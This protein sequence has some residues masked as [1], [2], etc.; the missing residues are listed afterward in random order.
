MHLNLPNSARVTAIT[1]A[2]YTDAI[3]ALFVHTY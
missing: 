3:Y 1:C 2:F